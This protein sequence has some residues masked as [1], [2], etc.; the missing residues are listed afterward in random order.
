MNKFANVVGRTVSQ[1]IQFGESKNG[2]MIVFTDGSQLEITA[3]STEGNVLDVD[4]IEDP[5][6]D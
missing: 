3:F 1:V 6:N 5:T 2:L 4:F